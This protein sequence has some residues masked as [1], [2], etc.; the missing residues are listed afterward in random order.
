MNFKLRN[1]VAATL[2]GTALLGFGANA[3]ADSTDDIL[4]ALIAKGVLTEEEGALLM[5]GRTGEKEAAEKKKES[6]ISAKYKDGITFESGDK[7]NSLTVNGRIQLDYRTYGDS[8]KD[9][10]VADTFDVRRAYLGAKGKFAKYYEFGIVTDFASKDDTGKDKSAQLDEAYINLHYWDQAQFKFGQFKMPFSLEE[11]TSSRFID[12]QERSLMTSY[13]PAK[14]IG[15]MLHGEPTKGVTYGLALSTGEGKNKIESS[16][17]TAK[18]D[19]VDV[20]AR[21]TVNIAEIMDNKDNVYHIGAAFSNGKLNSFSPS[22]STEG[23]GEKFFSAAYTTGATGDIERTRYGL[24]GAVA[25]GPV[26]LQSEW[27]RTNIDGKTIASAKFDDDID[28]WYAEALWTITGENYADSYKGGKFDRIKPKN[29]FNPDGAGIG[30]WEIGVRYSKLDA[31]DL[32]SGAVKVNNKKN[33]TPAAFN[34]AASVST[35]EADAWTVGVKWIPM[36]NWRFLA[37]YVRTD[38]DTPIKI[39]SKTF[40]SEDAFTVRAQMD[41]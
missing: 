7:E 33:M 15:A 19:G 13:V 37:N 21:A 31:S 18:Q 29:N 3:M 2:A 26:K 12:F 38:Y 25:L 4:N 1:L 36:P 32:N 22:S 23:K 41:F 28:V 30:A 8:N 6:S 20:I 40:D 34:A 27:M 16:S 14:E 11:Q 10:G 24:E 9:T 39:N 35:V 17:P 5:K